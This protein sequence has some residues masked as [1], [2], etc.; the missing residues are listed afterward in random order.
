MSKL[1]IIFFSFSLK[2]SFSLFEFEFGNEMKF[3]KGI[4]RKIEFNFN[5]KSLFKSLIENDSKS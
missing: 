2:F 1:K 5:N 4:E 3:N